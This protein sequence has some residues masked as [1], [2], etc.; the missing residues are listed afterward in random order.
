MTVEEINAIA[1]EAIDLQIGDVLEYC[2]K[3]TDNTWLTTLATVRGIL[4]M[5]TEVKV[6]IG[7]KELMKKELMEKG[8]DTN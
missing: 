7:E 4:N 5:A 2:G 3:D 6:A 8:G 1:I